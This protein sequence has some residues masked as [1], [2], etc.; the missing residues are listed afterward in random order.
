MMVRISG[1]RDAI[2]ET[3]FMAFQNDNRSYPIS[4]VPDDVGG[5]SYRSSPKGWIDRIV[6]PEYLMEKRVMK[7]L[8]H[9]RR[10][11]LFIDNCGGHCITPSVEQ[12]LSAVNTEISFFPP[13]MTD[14]I[15]PADSFVIKKLKDAWRLRWERYKSEIISRG[16]FAESSRKITNAGKHYYLR[17]AA[18]VVRDFN[19]MRDKHGLRYARKAMIRTGLAA[20][21]NGQWKERQL[22]PKLQE[23]IVKYRTHF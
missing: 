11:I 8:P 3:P 19:A 10:R 14:L 15:Q 4:G 6:I 17:L 2:V 23:I 9:G 1:G 18:A 20:N 16:G 22:F 7:L 5:V 21:F 12:A 13:D